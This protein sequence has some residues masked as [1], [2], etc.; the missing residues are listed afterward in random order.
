MLDEGT[1][2][3]RC[4][5]MIKCDEIKKNKNVLDTYDSSN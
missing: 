2:F 1:F 5:I 4:K 3:G